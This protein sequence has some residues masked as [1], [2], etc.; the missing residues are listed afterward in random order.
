[1]NS[2]PSMLDGIRVADMTTVIFGPYCTQMLA[3]LGADVIK[4]EPPHGD[5]GRTIGS[6]A[7]TPGMG[8]L[9]MSINRGK[10]SVSWDLKT[11]DGR[12]RLRSLIAT[13]DVFIHNVRSDAIRRLGFDYESVRS[14]APHIIYV[15]CCGFDSDGPDAGL[16]AY[17]DIVQGASGIASLL[18]RVDGRPEPRYL[19]LALA[20][21]VGGL[22][23][24]Q[25]TLA[26]IVHKL[27]FGQG[28]QV[29]VPMFE[30][31]TAFNL[32][33]HLGGAVFPD[34]PRKM[35]YSRQTSAARQPSRTADGYIC[36]APYND[37]RWIRFFEIIGRPDILAD[38]RLNTLALRQ[39]NRD[40][41]YRI[42]AELTPEK[43]TKEWLEI[44]RA[45]DIP[46]KQVNS[47]EDL[48]HDPQLRAVNFFRERLHPTE[49][50]YREVRPAVKFSARPDPAIGLPP[51]L[52][53]HNDELGAEL[54]FGPAAKGE[55]S[56]NLGKISEES[57]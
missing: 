27:R 15:H 14:L 23:A 22:Y 17:D 49:G 40:L 18:S 53:E 47:L 30:A 25:A 35:G 37:D 48:L 13:S 45:A 39:R 2:S 10:R 16:P 52:G 41:L 32:L 36:L 24:L 57:Q 54:G 5:N 20:D 7:R 51:H 28:Q 56:R 31:V 50:R 8:K 1:L 34:K 11:E 43:T 9:H 3:D 21:K 26:A 42:V 4:I 19:P 55:P 44:M 6:P 33:E 29:E 12:A 46:A 38:P